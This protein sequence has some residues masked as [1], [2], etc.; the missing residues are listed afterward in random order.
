MKIVL[1]VTLALFLVSCSDNSSEKKIEKPVQKKEMHTKEKIVIKHVAEDELS[2]APS[3]KKVPVKDISVEIKKEVKP[4]KAPL[5]NSGEAI[6][7]KCISCHGDLAQKSALNKSKIIQ[8]W[9]A[10]KTIKALNGYKNGSYGGSMK[11]V[12][13]SQVAQLSDEDIQA[14]AQYI[15]DITK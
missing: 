2:S 9:E 15:S 8:D 13:K 5:A 7:K 12:M 11:G 10:S 1:A 14:V 6:F 4:L 3:V